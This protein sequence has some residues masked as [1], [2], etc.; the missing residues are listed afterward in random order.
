MST[1]VNFNGQVLTQPQA[2]TRFNTAALTPA[3]PTQP[4]PHTLV[5]IGPANQG[6]NSLQTI[7]SEDDIAAKLGLDS[8][9]AQAAALALHPSPAYPVAPNPLKVW[10]VNPTTQGTINLPSGGASPATQ[11]ILTTTRYGEAA[12]YI[13]AS[14]SAGS[15]AGY[16][17]VIADDYSG[18]SYTL[19]NMALNVFSV[20]YSGTGTSPTITV[21]DSAV[22]LAATTSDTGG[23][24]TLTSN[25]TVTQ[26]VSQIN[27]LTGWNATV[28]DPNPNEVMAAFLDNVA[29][30]AVGT[31][32]ATAATLTANVSA[33]VVALNSGAQPLVTAARQADATSLAT[34]GTYT[35]AA[36]GSTGAATTTTWQ[37]A[38]TGLQTETDVLWVVPVSSESS[39][40]AMNQAH[41]QLMD[42]Q[43]YGR[44]GVVG[45]ASG[46]TVTEAQTNAAS[47]ASEY[48]DYL[49]NGLQGT[50]LQGQSVTFAPYL[51]AGQIAALESVLP[52]NNSVGLKPL[53]ATG[54]EQVFAAST[55]D[56]LIQS[57]CLV[58]KAQNGQYVVAKGQT[59]AALN[60]AAT[61]DQTQMAARNEVFV[62]EYGMNQVLN[63]FVE[64]PITPTTA[65]E[66]Q[67][68]IYTYLKSQA[69]GA[70]QP[71]PLIQAA[72]ALNAIQVTITGT[73]ITV[74]APA[75][76]T[77]V[78]DF[79]LAT[80]SASVDT[81]QAA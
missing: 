81:A 30:V 4:A 21:T 36:G 41:C 61:V 33:V 5:L 71:A 43:G 25:L 67:S 51:V 17:V 46:T 44:S 56:T 16:T 39:Y 60:P 73:V 52:L 20:W 48:T 45:G 55:V 3:A 2:R 78:A 9:L 76:P 23:T 26:L 49:V 54:L 63:A 31:T 8:D 53:T 57:G 29:S 42:G 37:A 58:L 14:V 35:Y 69:P 72:P 68:A 22:T 13:K 27:A 10:N 74:T 12:N 64:Q 79:V 28:L 70:S 77:I 34:P 1:T 7:T 47:L 18:D 32:S 40:W 50:N 15:V 62:L 66:V 80:L 38:Y 11:I 6:P 65:A 59:T 24:I 19:A 75:S